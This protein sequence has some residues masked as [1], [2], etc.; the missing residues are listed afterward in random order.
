MYM[1]EY[2]GR[3]IS[4][5]VVVSFQQVQLYTGRAKVN[6]HGAYCSLQWQSYIDMHLVALMIGGKAYILPFR[7]TFWRTRTPFGK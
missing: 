5:G 6:L 1:Y 2:T 3:N 4:I 7:L